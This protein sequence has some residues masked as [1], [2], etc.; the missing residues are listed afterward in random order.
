[1]FIF[2]TFITGTSRNFILTWKFKCSLENIISLPVLILNS[3]KY[4][5]RN[6]LNNLVYRINGWIYWTGAGARG[7][8]FSGSPI[9]ISPL[10]V[11]NNFTRFL[12]ELYEL[13]WVL[14]IRKCMR[15]TDYMAVLTVKPLTGQPDQPGIEFSLTGTELSSHQSRS[16][17]FGFGNIQYLSFF[18]LLLFVISQ[19]AKTLTPLIFNSLK[20]Q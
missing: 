17:L 8:G 16:P 15:V 1:M 20:G 12:Y 5:L 2:P 19:N 10:F 18:L 6:F 14:A 9:L 7:T 4:T 13:T 11:F 3:Q